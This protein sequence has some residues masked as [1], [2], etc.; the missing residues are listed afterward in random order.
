MSSKAVDPIFENEKGIICC[1]KD[2]AKPTP[3]PSLFR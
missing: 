2:S 1:N 3:V